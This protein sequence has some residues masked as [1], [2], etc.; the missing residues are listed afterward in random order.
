MEYRWEHM[1]NLKTIGRVYVNNFD[2]KT[3][4]G[5]DGLHLLSFGNQN[6]T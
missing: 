4:T 3:I 6:I 5:V 1:G 2:F